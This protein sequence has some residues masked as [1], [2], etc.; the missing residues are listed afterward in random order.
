MTQ[1]N[2]YTILETWHSPRTLVRPRQTLQKSGCDK[3]HFRLSC[4]TASGHVAIPVALDPIRSVQRLLHDTAQLLHHSRDM[5]QSTDTRE[6]SPNI[7][8]K[9]LSQVPFS[10]VMSHGR[11]HVAIPVALDP[12]RSVQRLLHDTA[13]L[14][15]HSRD[16]AQS[17]DTR[18]TS[19]NIAKKRLSQV[20]FSVVMSHGQWS[21]RHPSC[22]R[23][24][25]KCP[26]SAT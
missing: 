4:L 24:H 25:Q 26:T 17:T 3:C 14:L 23:P 12:I 16:M 15:H 18:E 9:R 8:K 1:H 13:Q 5:A 11:G 10:V 2:F 19:P 20:P 6:T 7:A 21:C 22:S